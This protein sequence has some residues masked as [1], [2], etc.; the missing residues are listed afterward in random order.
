MPLSKPAPRRHM[1]TR[2]IVC[3]GYRRDDGLWDIEGR[4]TDTKTYS[5]PN[6]DRGGIAAG[7][8]VHDMLI[9]LTLDGER[10]VVAAEAAT[11]HSPYAI[12]PHVAESFD[13]LEGLRIEAGWRKAVLAAFGGVRGCTHLTDLLLGP[14]ATTALQTIIPD[15]TEDVPV[16]Q[17]REAKWLID[18]CYAFRRDGP[19]VEREFP[20]Q[21]AGSD[22]KSSRA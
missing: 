5:F 17:R 16:R 15:D 6:H 14:L 3:R 4:L 1:H 10:T 22:G 19:V 18:K 2:E 8:P 11:E 12:C 9:R 7:E 20:E 13:R 21:Y